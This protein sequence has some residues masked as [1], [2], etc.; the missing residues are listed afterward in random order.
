MVET[1]V[2]F[3]PV[4]GILLIENE[5]ARTNYD[6]CLW[7]SPVAGIL[8]IEKS[9]RWVRAECFLGILLIENLTM[10]KLLVHVNYVCPAAG[11]VNWNHE[12][13]SAGNQTR[14]KFQSCCRDS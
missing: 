10:Y 1:Q 9:W 3:S 13:S 8:L 5:H 7:F 14:E 11:T 2:S 4:A 12:R 6:D